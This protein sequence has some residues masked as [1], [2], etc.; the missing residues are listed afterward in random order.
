MLKEEIMT[1]SFEKN[2]ELNGTP[3]NDQVLIITAVTAIGAI[4][5]KPRIPINWL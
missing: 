2:P 3:N 1:A 5:P 4:T